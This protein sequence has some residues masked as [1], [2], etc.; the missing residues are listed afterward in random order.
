MLTDISIAA[1][2][3]LTAVLA[4]RLPW[5]V[6]QNVRQGERYRRGLLD[7]LQQLPLH[8]VLQRY[9]IEPNRY[10]HSERVADVTRHM[11][12]C[13][14]CQEQQRC[15]GQLQAGADR[16]AFHFCPN[17]AELAPNTDQPGTLRAEREA[18]TA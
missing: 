15:L 18:A 12:R 7:Q 2:A 5:A 13:R 11:H 14:A 17:R 9:D 16:S 4:V 6:L 3:I 1:F 8:E 10:L